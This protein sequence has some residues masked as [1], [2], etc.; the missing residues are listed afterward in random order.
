MERAGG[1]TNVDYWAGVEENTPNTYFPFYH[2]VSVLILSFG[3]SKVFLTYWWSWMMLP[4]SFIAV[5]LFTYRAYGPAVSLYSVILMGLSPVW[6]EKQWGMPPQA[7][8]YVLTPL[9]FWALAE[10]RFIIAMLLTVCCAATHFTGIF[11]LP[12]LLIYG[13]QSHEARKPVLIMLG[14]LL[15]LG[16]PFTGF[17]FQRFKHAQISI[18]FSNGALLNSIKAA[19]YK[20]LDIKT[21]FHVYLGWLALAGLAVTCFRRKKFL[22]LAS[23][24]IAIFSMAWT[25]QEMRFWTTPALFIFPLLGGVALGSA[26]EAIEKVKFGKLTGFL[27]FILI[28]LGANAAFYYA[29]DRYPQTKIPTLVYLKSPEVW[30]RPK[31]TITA[32]DR[33]KITMLVNE[34]VKKDEFFWIYSSNNVNSYI[35]MRTGRS[36]IKS[37]TLEQNAMTLREGIKLIVSRDLPSSDYAMLDKI[38]NEYN[39]YILADDSKAAKVKTPKPLVTVGQIRKIFI[40]IGIIILI[41]LFNLPRLALT[42]MGVRLP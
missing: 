5:L 26:H 23:Y 34:N 29:S 20:M 21:T 10:K 25:S 3:A 37:I 31:L 4:L 8:V 12:F 11:L 6:L 28:F 42:T 7:L 33:E 17:I 27:F 15:I 38:N 18:G 32:E 14:A 9:V 35:A 16:L 2:I 13:L 22:I 1:W 36:T 41:D 39:A 24:F 30:Q 40:A 19:F